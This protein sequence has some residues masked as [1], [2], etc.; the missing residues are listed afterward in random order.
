M[1][2][3]ISQAPNPN[4][5]GDDEFKLLATNCYFELNYKIDD[6][7]YLIV[8]LLYRSANSVFVATCWGDT[9]DGIIRNLDDDDYVEIL[10]DTW[11]TLTNLLA[12]GINDK[13][14]NGA[15]IK[16]EDPDDGDSKWFVASVAGNIGFDSIDD[17]LC[18]NTHSKISL[19]IEQ[20]ITLFTELDKKRP[21]TLR[22]IGKGLLKGA[23]ILAIG[24]LFGLDLND[25]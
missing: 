24:S 7:T 16:L 11:P 22:A 19:V 10:H 5:Q 14:S 21:D 8:Y 23:A 4:A 15:L 6:S 18:A 2:Y 17:L 1:D 20:S 13:Y 25:A 9:F 12:N 3:F